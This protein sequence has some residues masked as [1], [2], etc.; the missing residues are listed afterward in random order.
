MFSGVVTI[1]FTGGATVV[2]VVAV[3]VVDVAE[4]LL[5]FSSL[6]LPPQEVRKNTMAAQNS[7]PVNL[8]CFIDFYFNN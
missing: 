6:P 2:V 5:V 4:S 7:M 3:S 1:V 8:N